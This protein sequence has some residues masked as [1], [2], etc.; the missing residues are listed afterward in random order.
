LIEGDAPEANAKARQAITG[1]IEQIRSQMKSMPKTIAEPPAMI[2]LGASARASEQI[3]LWSLGLDPA[4]TPEPRAAV[5]YGRARWIGPLMKGEEI[6]ERNLAGILSFIG[7]DCE[8][9]LDVSWTQGTRL[10]VRWDE[11]L[12][13]QVTKSLGFDPESPMIK[14]EASRIIRRSG[15]SAGKA[16]PDREVSPP[17][18]T[19][20]P[21][22]GSAPVF[23][24]RM[25]DA[26]Q[27]ASQT[28]ELAAAA[29]GQAVSHRLL[30]F[31]AG[32]TVIVIAAAVL[33]VA[34]QA[35]RRK[36]E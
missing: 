9:G 2:V 15:L 8:C 13:A 29:P 35:A 34:I 22:R 26:A 36:R 10:P 14:L 20:F 5:L 33:L 25:R 4:P 28:T 6:T 21:S 23:P 32:L 3:L 11:G 17:A 12:H 1:A 27:A 19:T 18:E 24:E 30:L 16:A 7:A 31:G